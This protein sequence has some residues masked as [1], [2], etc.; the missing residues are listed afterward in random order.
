MVQRPV[1]ILDNVVDIIKSN[2]K[3]MSENEVVE[4]SASSEA[5]PEVAPES[6]EAAPEA[7]PVADD[8]LS[9]EA[10]AE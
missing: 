3:I 4:G 8:N 7:A 5:A 1:R 6:T 2:Y 9:E 10:K